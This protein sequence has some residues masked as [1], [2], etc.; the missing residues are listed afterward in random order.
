MSRRRAR[1]TARR[2]DR[3]G[4]RQRRRDVFVPRPFAGLAD[5]PEWVALREFV[6][7]A[8]APLRLAPDVE[9]AHGSRPVT[10]ATLL[11]MASPAMVRG[12]GSVMVGLQREGRSGDVSR[13]LAAALLAALAT[14]EPGP[15]AVPPADGEGPRLQDLLVDGALEVTVHDDFAFWHDDQY[16][17][18]DVAASMERANSS[19]YPTVRMT[20]ARAAYWCRMP[21]RSHLRW[22]LAEPE[23]V[24]LPA[25]ARVSAAGGLN[26]DG[27]TRFAGMFRAH[28]L[29]VP[30]WDLP[31]D[32]PAQRWEE[33]LAA[34]A[35][36]YAAALEGGTELTAAE[37]RARQ[38]LVG[39]QL[40]LR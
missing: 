5:E 32:D 9:A 8:T 40:T 16:E 15:L 1:G 11:P 22:T 23:D 29:L 27:A 12:D 34:F 25:L 14:E 31:R 37:R 2:A 10:L 26:L 33:P 38:G 4:P 36:R 20:A 18:P 21:Q 3:V 17:D 30:V 24:A 13:D 7:S 39:R 6:P 28:G 35:Q 19:V